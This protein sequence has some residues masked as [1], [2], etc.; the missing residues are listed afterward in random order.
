MK[1]INILLLTILIFIGCAASFTN[2]EQITGYNFTKP[3]IKFELP[4][5][6]HEISG[7]TLIDSSTF[8]C[9]Q[10]EN[11][12][13]F[14]YDV[15]NNKILKQYTFNIDGD[16]EGITRV[17]KDMYILRS[18]GTL[19]ELLNYES[20]NF[21]INS[22]VTGIPADNNEGLCYDAKNKRLLIAAK[23][24]VLKGPQYKDKRVIYGFDLKTKKLSTE[25]AFDIDVQN[26]KQFALDKKIELP[27]R[28]KKKGEEPILRFRTSDIGIHPITNKLF[29]LSGTEHLFFIFSMEGKLEHME[30]LDPN[31]FNKSEGITFFENGDLLITNEGQ[32]KKPT[33]LRFKYKK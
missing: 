17:G 9:I 1:R 13:L 3:D 5:I 22:Y 2:N 33:L 25:P 32:E 15:I 14:I 16:Y 20:K 11:G 4:P 26:I 27:T 31:L 24:K 23:G 28:D 21:K 8:A 12:I 18:D 30:N 7:L 19:F 29:L 10:D 6:L